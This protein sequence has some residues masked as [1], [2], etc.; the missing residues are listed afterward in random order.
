V[1]PE[2]P[3]P[4]I[5]RIIARLP[6]CPAVVFSRFG[7]VLLQTRSAIELFG[8]HRRSGGPPSRTAGDRGL[9]RYR[10]PGLG[11][12]ELYRQV[13]VDP[14]DHQVL[15]FFTAVPGSPSDEKLR[16]LAGV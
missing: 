6:E 3:G 9:R 12:L 10:H 5:A 13:L 1:E 15:L 8:D 11:E 16:R 14:E 2:Q 7:E 4:V